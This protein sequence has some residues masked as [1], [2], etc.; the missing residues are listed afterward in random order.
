MTE[1]RRIKNGVVEVYE[2]EKFMGYYDTLDEYN[3][4]KRRN[5]EKEEAE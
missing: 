2:D 4:E 3:D 5:E 1:W